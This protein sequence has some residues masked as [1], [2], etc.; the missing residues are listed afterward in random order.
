MENMQ[1]WFLIFVTIR[2]TLILLQVVVLP[3]SWY[4][5][6][7]PHLILSSKLQ[8]QYPTGS[9]RKSYFHGFWNQTSIKSDTFK[10]MP[11]QPCRHKHFFAASVCTHPLFKLR[12]PISNVMMLLT[13]SFGLLNSYVHCCADKEAFSFNL[14]Y[15]LP[16]MFNLC[17]QKN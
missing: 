17:Q 9:V 15:L 13:N 6:Q 3:M 16:L 4:Q 8:S 7:S 12:G 11:T 1:D 10:V 14:F 2:H 5:D